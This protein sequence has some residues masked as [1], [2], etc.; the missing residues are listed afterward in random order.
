M[1]NFRPGELN[2]EKILDGSAALR[3]A[4]YR[5]GKFDELFGFPRS[6]LNSAD[7]NIYFPYV[8][9]QRKAA[10][11]PEMESRMTELGKKEKLEYTEQLE[12]KILKNYKTDTNEFVGNICFNEDFYEDEHLT[13]LM[14]TIVWDF[15][16]NE[17]KRYSNS[18]RS[19]WPKTNFCVAKIDSALD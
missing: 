17:D 19:M 12:L 15:P 10:F 9:N 11:S 1:K 5:Y 3:H 6:A 13:E 2:S 7:M 4:F 16:I 14:E 18:F 8:D